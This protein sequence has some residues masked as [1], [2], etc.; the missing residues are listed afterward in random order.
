MSTLVTTF[1]VEVVC[2]SCAV[3][4]AI[5]DSLK[6][7]ALR[8]TSASHPTG[9]REIYCPNGHAW[10]YTGK[11]EAMKLKE[12]LA[13]SE[14]QKAWAQARAERLRAE[15]EAARRTAATYKG[16]ATRQ[17]KRAAAAVCPVDGCK[18]TIQ[19]MAR[20]LRT[21]HPEYVAEHAHG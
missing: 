19:Q 4:Y 14:R 13:D 20:H 6:E 8:K 2:P 11:T 5:P 15:A 1:L 17:R 9:F 16:H 21:K 7:S 10:H 18:R 12:Q 3:P